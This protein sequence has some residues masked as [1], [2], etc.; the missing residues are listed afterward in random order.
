MTPVLTVDFILQF[1]TML[2]QML[3]YSLA[4]L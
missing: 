4:Q 2:M 3:K 1:D